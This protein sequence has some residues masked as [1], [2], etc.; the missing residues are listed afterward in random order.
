MLKKMKSLFKKEK[1]V[2]LES[3]TPEELQKEN[4]DRKNREAVR[5]LQKLKGLWNH[6]LSQGNRQYRK[7]L[8]REFISNDKLADEMID[9]TIKYH[10]KQ[11]LE[12]KPKVS[13]PE[14]VTA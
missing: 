13:K 8:R 5:E 4:I 11:I 7:A 10:E 9:L 6:L 12:N 2:I 3:K 14:E 1:P